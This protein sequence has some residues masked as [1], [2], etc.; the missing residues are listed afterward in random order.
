MFEGVIFRK[1]L[2]IM[3]KPLL[4]TIASESSL[5]NSDQDIIENF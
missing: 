2:T 4:K 5:Q 3:L 1:D